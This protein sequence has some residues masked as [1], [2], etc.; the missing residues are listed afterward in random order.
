MTVNELG[1][2]AV[3]EMVGAAV[4]FGAALVDATRSIGAGELAGTGTAFAGRIGVST[5]NTNTL[6]IVRAVSTKRFKSFL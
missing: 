1:T 5:P 4:F 2:F 3:P 6:A